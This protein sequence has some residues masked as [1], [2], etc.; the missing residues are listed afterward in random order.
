MIDESSQAQAAAS[1]TAPLIE[2]LRRHPKRIVFTEGE[3]LRVLRVAERLVKA[4]AAVPILLGER[5]RILALAKEH[6][7]DLT[8]VKVISPK[9]SGDFTLFCQR[10]LKVERYRGA[11]VGDPTEIVA[12]PHYFGAMMVQYGQAD[13][14][15]GGNLA[16]PA[17]LFRALI[18]TIKPLPGVPKIFGT[19][20]L[21]AP[22]LNH[23][24][25]SGLLLLSD[26]GL[27]PQPTVEQLASIAVET[28]KIARHFLGR[29]ARVA[30]L[31]HSTKG[32][33]STPDALR[34]AAATALA[35]EHAK[36]QFLDMKIDG[37]EQA[38]VALDPA[39]AEIKLPD[40]E[41]RPSADVLVFPNLDAA[42]I[43]LKLLQHCAG[44]MNYGQ[45]IVGLAR[46][47]AQVPR[48]ASEETIFGTAAA[49][50]VEAIKYHEAYPDGE[51]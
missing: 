37:E 45:L 17:T 25:A 3:D 49:V 43:S 38:D 36:S 26:S 11:Q 23:F 46:P 9:G 16:L 34:V 33:A 14:L 32:S 18:H 29:P 30:M 50:G 24:G 15:V 4:E 5:D 47:A 21:A 10:L 22:H 41:L 7:V 13:A 8:F 28:G 48:T 51:V 20:I 42:H 2:K 19:T 12:R 1:F 27:I 6:H 44:A 35:R 31:S 40:S 39:A